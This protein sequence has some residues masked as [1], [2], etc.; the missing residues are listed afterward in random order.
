MRTRLVG[1][2]LATAAA[3]LAGAQQVPL[4]VS[5]SGPTVDGNVQPGEYLLSRDLDG[6]TLSMARTTDRVYLAVS[7]PT[8]G[9]V[10]VGTGTGR[11][12]GS[13]IF[14]GYVKDGATTFE[15]DLGRGHRH[16]RAADTPVETAHAL[17]ESGGRTMLEVELDASQVILAEAS[18]LRVIVAYGARD[19]LT[20]YHRF[21]TSVSVELQ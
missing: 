13:R 6:T 2:V 11:M 15:E 1:I 19:S 21:R 20:A 14:I 10:A 5:P 9:W 3:A 7:A 12:E 8:S 17:V 16:G 18:E 4:A